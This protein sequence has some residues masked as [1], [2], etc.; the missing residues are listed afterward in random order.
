M[1]SEGE[2]KLNLSCFRLLGCLNV[3]PLEFSRTGVTRTSTY[4]KA[5]W[6]AFLCVQ[7][8]HVLFSVWV[9]TLKIMQ[10]G[11]E[12]IPTM[13]VDYCLIAG[14]VLA[15]FTAVEN[16][17]VW[18][19]VTTMLMNNL[20][21]EPDLLKSQVRNGPLPMGY[22][23]LELYTMLLGCFAYPAAAV[24]SGV[25]TW[26]Y[27]WPTT[28]GLHFLPRVVFSLLEGAVMLSWISWLH[29]MAVTQ[30]TFMEKICL[31]LKGQ[32]LKIRYESFVFNI[33]SESELSGHAIIRSL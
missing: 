27:T 29:F 8:C 25:S 16:F 14:P 30:I 5:L 9:M 20:K 10:Y 23:C 11:S 13:A 33:S 6:I 1:L 21:P 7:L 24:I 12:C 2:N 3:I 15:I 18:P 19:E 4:R 28:T 26:I 31:T 32:A 17:L 22:T